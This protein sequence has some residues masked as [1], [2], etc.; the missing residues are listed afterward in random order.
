MMRP[1]SFPTVLRKAW[2]LG[3]MNT[4]VPEE[5]GGSGLG[6]MDGVLIG[7]ETAWGCTGISTA[8]EA[9]TLAEAPVIVAGTDAQKKKYLGRMT[10]VSF[11]ASGP[12]SRTGSDVWSYDGHSQRGSLRSQRRKMITN[13]GKANWFFVL[14]KTDPDAKHKGMTGFIVDADPR[15]SLVVVKSEHGSTGKRYPRRE[16]RGCTRARREPAR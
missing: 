16:I 9:N 8:I 12:P 3:L 6:V 14:A 5:Y 1:A 2:E 13:A 10:E 4:H 11:A 7:E 15:A